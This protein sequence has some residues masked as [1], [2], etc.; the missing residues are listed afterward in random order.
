MSHRGDSEALPWATPE[1]LRES[2]WACGLRFYNLMTYLSRLSPVSRGGIRRFESEQ[3]LPG[4]VFVLLIR[5]R[6]RLPPASS[7][8]F[9]F[10]QARGAGVLKISSWV[11]HYGWHWN[12]G[13]PADFPRRSAR[14]RCKEDSQDRAGP[15]QGNPRVQRRDDGDQERAQSG[16]YAAADPAPAPP[17]ARKHGATSRH[18]STADRDPL[19][20]SSACRRADG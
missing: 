10:C 18:V 19:G 15:R 1:C 2:G 14:F 8:A 9:L 5:P 4:N 7:T 12:V 3:T 17:A 13:G 6:F 11:N 16:R 20:T